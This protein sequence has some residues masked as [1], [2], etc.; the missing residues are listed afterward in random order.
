MI[1]QGQ[2]SAY[3]ELSIFSF[4]RMRNFILYFRSESL[5]DFIITVNNKSV[6]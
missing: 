4:L 5:I 2:T 3:D 6:I 1:G